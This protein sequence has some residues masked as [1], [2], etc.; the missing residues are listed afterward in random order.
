[1]D[2]KIFCLKCGNKT[3]EAI[4]AFAYVCKKCDF[5]MPAFKIIDLVT[6]EQFEYPKRISIGN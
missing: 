6:N 1:M 4:N 2:A 3:E 5:K